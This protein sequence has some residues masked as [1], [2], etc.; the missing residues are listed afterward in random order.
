M[1]GGRNTSSGLMGA[2]FASGCGG[3]I[4]SN[5]TMLLPGDMFAFFLPELYP[6]LNAAIKGRRNYYYGDH[7]YFRRKQ[8][9]RITK[10]AKQ[11]ELQGSAS[12]HRW[13]R[14]GFRIKPWRNNGS[15]ILLCPQTAKF[16]E[17][18]GLNRNQWINDTTASLRQYTDRQIIVHDK[19]PGTISEAIFEAALH[20]V[21]AVV[22]YTSVAGAQAAIHG[23]PCF[24]THS[25]VSQ[26]FGSRDL[27]R[28]ENPVKPD[29]RAEMAWEL[30]ENQWT[31]DEIRRGV[32]W[33]K[34][35]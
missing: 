13:E 32:A 29:N 34:L 28:I 33:A 12:P 9:Y 4:S 16:F 25:C 19:V 5:P 15:K 8:Y 20:D 17:L 26:Q 18:Q 10:N 3:R 6:L 11:W 7:A 1:I 22:V 30:A 35:K 23:I 2:A 24:A 27:S 31:I 21:W 14:L